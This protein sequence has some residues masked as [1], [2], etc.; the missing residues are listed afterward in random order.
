MRGGEKRE[1]LFVGR[2]GGRRKEKEKRV[3]IKKKSLREK[4]WVVKTHDENTHARRATHVHFF[5]S[6]C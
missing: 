6:M 3:P 2:G 5:V 1:V 4:F